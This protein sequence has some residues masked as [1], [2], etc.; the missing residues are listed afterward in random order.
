MIVGSKSESLSK[1]DPDYRT[2][3]QITDRSILTADPPAGA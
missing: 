1:S 2:T 3:V